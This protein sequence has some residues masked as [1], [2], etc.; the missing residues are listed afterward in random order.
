MGGSIFNSAGVIE[1]GRIAEGSRG[2]GWGGCTDRLVPE[3]SMATR[4]YEVGTE[5]SFYHVGRGN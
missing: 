1:Q 4:L 5:L 3:G 2:R